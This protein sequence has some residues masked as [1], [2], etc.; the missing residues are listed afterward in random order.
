[1]TRGTELIAK[2]REQ[3]AK[4][5]GE[6]PSKVSVSVYEYARTS[7][8]YTQAL[9]GELERALKMLEVAEH[10]LRVMAS[11]SSGGRARAA[12]E[13]LNRLRG[14]EDIDILRGRPQE[15]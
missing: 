12:L 5:R 15:K 9:E 7:E 3:Q 2:V 8:M 14:D 13:E 6:L 11:L 10:H 1:M 4:A